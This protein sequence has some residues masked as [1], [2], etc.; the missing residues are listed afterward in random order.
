MPHRSRNEQGEIKS[1][2]RAQLIINMKKLSQI[3]NTLPQA[4]VS[5]M[6]NK[7]QLQGSLEK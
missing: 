5:G 6:D 3:T 1:K 7:T 2:T 4:K